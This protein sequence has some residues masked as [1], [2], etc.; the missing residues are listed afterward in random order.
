[1]LHGTLY[2]LQSYTFLIIFASENCIF[3]INDL[4]III[5]PLNLSVIHNRI[6]T[7]KKSI[8]FTDYKNNIDIQK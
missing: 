7:S 4:T 3:S 6:K 8:H 5:D 1:M 2:S